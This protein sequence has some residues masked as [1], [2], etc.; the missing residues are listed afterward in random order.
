MVT[1]ASLVCIRCEHPIPASPEELAWVC[2]RCGQ[3]M[4]LEEE[5][6]LLPLEIH[7]AAGTPPG[8]KGSPFWAAMGTLQLARQTYAS[9]NKK[10]SEAAQFWARPR[11][12]FIPA[13]ACDLETTLQLGVGLLR[14]PPRLTP[15]EAVP[16][17]SVTVPPQDVAPLAEF[18]VLAVEA[19]R[20][21]LLREIHFDLRLEQPELW[22]L[23]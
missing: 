21:D 9:F 2:E 1:L 16:F 10:D 22:V 12:F 8:A 15:G 23:P 6:G 7:F 5:G 4:I 17:L 3:G 13:Y 11:Q 19:E 18:I 20:A 14:N